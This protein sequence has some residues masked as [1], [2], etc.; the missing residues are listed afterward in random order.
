MV[1]NKRSRLSPPA[2][3]NQLLDCAAEIIEEQGLSSFTMDALATHAGV[4]NRLIYKYFDTRLELLQALLKRGFER[5]SSG[6]ADALVS[7]QS[8]E[9]AVTIVVTFNFVEARKRNSL[10]I[11]RNQPEIMEVIAAAARNEVRKV[12]VF[13]VEKLAETYPLSRHQAEQLV[14]MASGASRAAAAS[15]FNI[16]GRTEEELIRQVVRFILGGV[17][18]LLIEDGDDGAH[19]TLSA[20]IC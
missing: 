15:R 1:A 17:E 10:N 2:R 11:L 18:S 16:K 13:L 12:G 8:A 5:F 6:I 19:A 3:V 14:T 9:D 20:Q 4:S 7:A